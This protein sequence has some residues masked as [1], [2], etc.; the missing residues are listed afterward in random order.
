MSL[1]KINICTIALGADVE[2]VNENLIELNKLYNDV[3]LYIICPKKDEYLFINSLIDKNYEIVTEDKFI[4]FEDFESIFEKLSIH[5]NYKVQFKK[6]LQWYYALF[7]KFFFIH[8]FFEKKESK[9]IIWEGDS[10]ILKKI[11]FFD[12]E[13]SLL[14]VYVD[15]YHQIFYKTCEK[16]LKKLPIYYG[17]FITMFG[18]LTK[19][20]F[21]YLNS[22]L[23]F[24]K[25]NNSD[26]CRSFSI[27]AL[28]SIFK[29][30]NIYDNAMFSD[31]DLIGIS[32]QNKSFK[33]Q[34]PIFFLRSSLDG[35][36][37]KLQK[38]IAKLFGS[39]LVTYEHR[40]PNKHSKGML[41]RNQ[42]WK[43]FLM[44]MPYYFFLFQFNKFKFNFNYY[45]KIFF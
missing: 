30:H 5:I 25:L 41:L 17:S 33:K 1:D 15:Y 8:Y 6:R 18:S 24:E 42:T 20:E 22:S 28:S 31:Y 37:T 10:V 32:N 9:L 14:Y 19:N 34:T 16:L 3:K 2:I 40:H 4:S 44:I 26:F 39:H 38:S 36:L 7:L 35:K 43:R 11:D 21:D 12:N 45:L 23:G 29:I 13:S 27:K